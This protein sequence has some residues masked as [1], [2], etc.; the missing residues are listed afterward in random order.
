MVVCDGCSLNIHYK[1]I[2]K[3]KVCNNCLRLLKNLKDEDLENLNK[4]IDENSSKRE[5]AFHN[6]LL[7][8]Y[9][10]KCY[11]RWINRLK[12]KE[13]TLIL[14]FIKKKEIYDNVK[15]LFM[16]YKNT[17]PKDIDF[18]EYNDDVATYEVEYNID[19][20]RYLD[21]IGINDG[22]IVDER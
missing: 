21:T 22:F 20:S 18:N 12:S 6:S 17:F 1:T 9:E 7:K 15:H 13:I 4:T 2:Q 8:Q 19:T 3:Q 10:W 5:Y 16:E 11:Y 14:K